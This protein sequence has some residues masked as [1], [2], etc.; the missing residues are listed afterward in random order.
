MAQYFPW[1]AFAAEWLREGVLPLWNPYQFCGTP[2]LAN[3]QSA[4]LYPL[5]ALFW[6]LAVAGAF[7]WS[8]WLHLALTGWFAYLLLRRFGARPWAALSGAVVWQGNGFLLAWIHLP[9]VLCTAAWLPL[10]LLWSERALR[11]GGVR[12][13]ALVAVPVGL[14]GLAG[15]PQAFL[16]C[17][18]LV[19]FYAVARILSR[20]LRVCAAERARRLAALALAGGGLGIGIAAAQLV[21]TVS[22]LGMAHRTFEPGPESYAAFLSHA[23]PAAQLFGLLVPHA[24]GHP[25]F[26][27]YVGALNYAELACYVGIVGLALALWGMTASRTWHARFFGVVAVLVFAA[28]LGSVVNWPLYHWVP[29]LARS[30]GPTRMLLLAAFSLS[31][32]AGLGAE[33]LLSRLEEREGRAVAF[34]TLILAVLAIGAGLWRVIGAPELSEIRP[35]VGP[36]VGREALLAGAL[37]AAAAVWAVLAWRWGAR[38]VWPAALV[39]ILGVDVLLAA[40]GHLHVCPAAWAYPPV[41]V[42]QSG[43]GR[44]IGNAAD[45]PIN[46]FPEA[47]L[48]PNSATVYHLRDAFGYDSLYLARYRDFAAAIQ[49]GDPSPPLNGNLLLARLSRTYGL[50]MMSLA[51][52]ERVLSP[53]RVPGLAM[54]RAGAYYTQRNPHALARAWVCTSSLSVRTHSEAL[55]ALL[56]LWPMENALIITGPDLATDDRVGAPETPPTVEDV[57]PNAVEVH[58][59]DGGG[60]YLFLADSYAPGW[61]AYSEGRELPVRP[62]NV[63]FRVTAPPREASRVVFRYEPDS[64]RLGVFAMLAAL[65]CLGGIAGYALTAR[66]R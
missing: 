20:E 18:V 17:A 7:G 37:C 44:V 22:L 43:D 28:V 12:R 42:E 21:P 27:S 25:A 26:G 53:E 50:D 49:H 56:Q 38:R 59:P 1:R 35:A 16:L 61:R 62:A 57:S 23:M 19:S 15:H 39:A 55:A 29:G 11:R 24:F 41:R 63:T 6:V 51:G 36:L 10:I 52:V 13:A 40:Q 2:F 32:L 45:W 5:N 54:E 31:L 30:G 4:V 46:R 66:D 3:S 34:F 48:P 8:A 33:A 65:C 14:C 58:L 64:F 47:V 9:T 60:G